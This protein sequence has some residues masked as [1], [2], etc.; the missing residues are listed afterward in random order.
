MLGKRTD[1]EGAV[2]GS[3]AHDTLSRNVRRPDTPRTR[4]SLPVVGQNHPIKHRKIGIDPH[5]TPI[6]WKIDQMN[7]TDVAT[8]VNSGHSEG[9][10]D[11]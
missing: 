7:M 3:P 6:G 4:R 8:A 9:P 11:L 5:T 2:R 10:G 1:V